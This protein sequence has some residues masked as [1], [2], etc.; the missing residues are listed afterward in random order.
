MNTPKLSRREF[1]LGATALWLSACAPKRDWNISLPFPEVQEPIAS[2]V[3]E[4]IESHEVL[5]ENMK[6]QNHQDDIWLFAKI[7][8]KWVE[9]TSLVQKLIEFQSQNGLTADANMWPETLKVLYTKVFIQSPFLTH[10]QQKRWE[11]YTSLQNYEA[12]RGKLPTSVPNPFD[13]TKFFGGGSQEDIYGFLSIPWTY[14]TQGIYDVPLQDTPNT[15][16]IERNTYGQM[17]LRMYDMT[18]NLY[19]SAY[20]TGGT[21]ENQSPENLSIETDY[22]HLYHVSSSYPEETE[23]GAPMYA[24]TRVNTNGIWIH[25][26]ASMIDGYDH[27]HGCFRVGLLYAQALH[28]Y[29]NAGNTL[30]IVIWDLYS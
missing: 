26:S 18:G 3:W 30:N 8:N 25:S 12:D 16:Y 1:F 20:V 29:V 15:L 2:Q 10:V 22:A 4:I 28:D 19:I 9:D 23:W 24:A 11:I 13:N 7:F 6:F 14:L 17:I 27:S 21:S 5:F